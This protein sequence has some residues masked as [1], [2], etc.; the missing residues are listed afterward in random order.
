MCEDV[1][2]S[3]VGDKSILLSVACVARLQTVFLSLNGIIQVHILITSLI[4]DLQFVDTL[5]AN[6]VMG[7][8]C[9]VLGV[10]W[11]AVWVST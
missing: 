9:W 10:G 2:D 6:W 1:V 5:Y 11:M 8:G 7:D 3:L 4:Y